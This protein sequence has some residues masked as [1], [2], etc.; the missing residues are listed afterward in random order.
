MS[1]DQQIARQQE[2][3]RLLGIN[4]SYDVI[5]DNDG[6]RNNEEVPVFLKKRR[7]N[8]MAPTPVVNLGAVINPTHRSFGLEST[9][10]SAGS[11]SESEFQGEDF[12]EQDGRSSSM[13]PPNAFGD[14]R[15]S[16]REL[17]AL[18]SK[19]NRVKM[20]ESIDKLGRI[21]FSKSIYKKH[22]RPTILNDAVEYILKVERRKSLYK[23]EVKLGTEERTMYYLSEL[24]RKSEIKGGGLCYALG[25]LLPILCA[26]IS[27]EYSE[28]WTPVVD[29]S[30]GTS[31]LVCSP[32]C[33]IATSSDAVHRFR[34]KSESLCFPYDTG[35]P[36][37]VWTQQ[38]YEV[39]NAKHLSDP[40]AFIRV[41]AAKTACFSMAV[42]VPIIVQHVVRAVVVF[43][44]GDTNLT[45]EVVRNKLAF[46]INLLTRLSVAYDAEMAR[47]GI[48]ML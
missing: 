45:D 32:Q 21:V 36:G 46:I 33:H 25:K 31:T 27:W 37:R 39:L 9:S 15:A 13:L 1:A 10:Q 40:G 35:L 23:A 7:T 38:R 20:N 14:R 24:V 5:P 43:F 34:E 42:G 26:K 28:I 19:R 11:D 4:V 47:K 17:Q 8:D 22:T 18:A 48:T 41:S 44:T 2:L 3:S 16:S 30:S 12:G 29:P 6:G